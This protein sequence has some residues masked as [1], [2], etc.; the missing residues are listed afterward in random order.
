MRVDE[1]GSPDLGMIASV[2]EHEIPI[3]EITGACAPIAGD[4]VTIPIEHVPLDQG[5]SAVRDLDAVAFAT[6]M[7]VVMDVVVVNPHR[8]RIV[9]PVDVSV[10]VADLDRGAW[11]AVAPVVI[12]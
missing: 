8:H 11:P 7:P 12:D 9:D 4:R 5:V 2:F 6:L 3:G 1:G 10:I